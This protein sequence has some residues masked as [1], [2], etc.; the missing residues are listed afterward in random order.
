[1]P[2]SRSL[3]LQAYPIY[4]DRWSATHEWS[5]WNLWVLRHSA[6]MAF[7]MEFRD[8]PNGELALQS[9]TPAQAGSSGSNCKLERECSSGQHIFAVICDLWISSSLVCTRHPPPPQEPKRTPNTELYG[10]GS[11]NPP[12]WRTVWAFPPATCND[13]L[14]KATWGTWA[15]WSHQYQKTRPRRHDSA[16]RTQKRRSRCDLPLRLENKKSVTRLWNWWH[17][18]G[19]ERNRFCLGLTRD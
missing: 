16:E 10:R 17:V 14:W 9:S 3:P 11:I 8:V 15:L 19:D 2:P 18:G 1:M 7:L 4:T 6:W 13:H 5:N 12:G